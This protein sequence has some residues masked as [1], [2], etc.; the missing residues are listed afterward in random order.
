LLIGEIF[1]FLWYVFII[2]AQVCSIIYPS[3]TNH[4]TSTALR[5]F[6]RMRVRLRWMISQ[7]AP[8]EERSAVSRM[9][10]RRPRRLVCTI[11]S[12][13]GNGRPVKSASTQQVNKWMSGQS[14][15]G[16]TGH[17]LVNRTCG[18]IKER[19]HSRRLGKGPQPE[20]KSES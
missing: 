12:S 5:T 18:L 9:M 16:E 15:R 4:H 20:D 2:N 19:L 3:I 14:L 11:S 10:T 7:I 17:S 13:L 8:T 1:Q 6:S